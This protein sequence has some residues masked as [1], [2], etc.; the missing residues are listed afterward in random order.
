MLQNLKGFHEGRK[1]NLATD[2]QTLNILFLSHM[3]S[4]SSLFYLIR[5]LATRCISLLNSKLCTQ[6]IK[7]LCY[8]SQKGLWNF[9]KI[10]SSQ[11]HP[12][13]LSFF[14]KY[15]NHPIYY[16]FFHHLLKLIILFFPRKV[17]R[18]SFFTIQLESYVRKIK[19]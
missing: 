2:L 17:V 6:I 5:K 13:S 8:Q 4:K 9:S 16:L 14:K 15:H 12:Y 7:K 3:L 11:N 19:T 10:L 1:L 18:T